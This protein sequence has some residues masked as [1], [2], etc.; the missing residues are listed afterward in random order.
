MGAKT[1]AIRHVGHAEG[2]LPVGCGIG[3]TVVPDLS[4]VN[5]HIPWLDGWQSLHRQYM[6]LQQLLEGIGVGDVALLR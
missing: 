3:R 6:S 2:A 1:G 4:F 5:A